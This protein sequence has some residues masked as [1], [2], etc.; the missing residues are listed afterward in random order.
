MA[1]KTTKAPKAAAS[2]VADRR[3]FKAVLL[4]DVAG[5]GVHGA[6]VQFDAAMVSEAGLKAGTDYRKATSRDLCIAGQG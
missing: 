3:P 6:I 4:R 5:I 1:T 2:A